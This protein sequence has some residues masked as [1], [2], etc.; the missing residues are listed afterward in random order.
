MNRKR[1]LILFI[2]LIAFAVLIAGGFFYRYAYRPSMVRETC[3]KLAEKAA[4]KDLF[5]YEIIYR[6]CLRTNGI[7]YNELGTDIPAG[8]R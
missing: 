2:S 8:N 1:F 5:V 7:E 3:S 4:E 6:H